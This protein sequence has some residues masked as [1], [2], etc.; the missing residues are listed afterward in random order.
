MWF[1]LTG[2]TMNA[3]DF[4][5]DLVITMNAIDHPKHQL[6]LIVPYHVHNIVDI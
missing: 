3:T 2:H 5:N 6:Y 1:G 4:F